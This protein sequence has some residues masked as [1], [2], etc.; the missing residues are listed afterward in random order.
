MVWKFCKPALL[1]SAVVLG[2]ALPASAQGVAGPYLAAVQAE[3]RG[4]VAAAARYFA[5]ALA[6]DGSN[7]AIMER[8]MMNQIAAGNIAE[9]IA[10]ARLFDAISPGHHL[11][12]LALAA[13][14]LRDGEHDAVQE[15]LADRAPFVARVIEAWSLMQSGSFDEGRA[16]LDALEATTEN[17]RQGQVVAATHLGLMLAAAD[18]DSEAVE[19]FERVA[20]MPNGDTMLMVQARA[21]ALARLGRT[22]EAV[23]VLEAWAAVNFADP[24]QT[25]LIDELKAG[26]VPRPVV[27]DAKEGAADVLYSVARLLVRGQSRD[28]S[29]AYAQIA[30]YLDPDRGDAKLLVAQ[31][32]DAGGQYELAVAAYESIAADAPEALGALI[33]KS[34]VLFESGEEDQAIV[35][36]QAAVDQFP[37]SL[38][39]QT[40]LGDLLRRAQRFEESVTAY[41]AAVA[42][43]PEVTRQYWQLFYRRGIALERAGIWERAEADFRLSLELEP[44]QPDVLNYLGYSLVEM[45]QNLDE[46]EE[47]IQKAVD[48]RPEDGYIVDSLGWIYY[49]FGE[50][51]LAV[52]HLGRA[53]ELRPIDPV[54]NDH[55]GD[56]L[57]MVGRKI[58]ARFQWKRALS[59]DPE[60]KDA[61]R[62]RRKL[63]VG[64]DVILAEEAEEGLPGIIGRQTDNGVQPTPNDGG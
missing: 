41:D 2:A 4:D 6:R 17:G 59:F 51:D 39:A 3:Q 37:G 7:V 48:Q 34:E 50:F 14:G 49:R 5:R 32:F 57:W 24:S 21:G 13:D 54:I 26:E 16:I 40:S 43:L 9:G 11:G 25:R 62:I 23:A 33:G 64:L 28:V 42:L 60:D 47:M 61:E 38:D 30:G 1:A 22:D 8:A 53:V 55:L 35:A 29:L 15:M 12:V 63:D 18:R 31:I 44:D 19:V 10:I 36:M 52:Q 45:G 46:A 27:S 58:E 56:A 20:A